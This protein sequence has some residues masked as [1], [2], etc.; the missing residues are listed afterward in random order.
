MKGLLGKLT[1]EFVVLLILWKRWKELLRELFESN[2][3]HFVWPLALALA[4][5]LELAW[6]LALEL[7]VVSVFYNKGEQKGA[8]AVVLAF[9]VSYN[10]GGR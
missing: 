6:A 7:A 8:W 9:V 1:Q 4:L 3:E 5:A 2:K 10:K